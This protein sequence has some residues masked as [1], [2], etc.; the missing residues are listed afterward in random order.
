MAHNSEHLKQRNHP[1]RA[2]VSLGM[3]GLRRSIACT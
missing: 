2:A 1:P 3:P